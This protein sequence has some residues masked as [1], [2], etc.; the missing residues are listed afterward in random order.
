MFKRWLRLL[1][2][3]LFFALCLNQLSGYGKGSSSNVP[4][5]KYKIGVIVYD[6]SDVMQQEIN[7][8][9]T[10]HLAPAFN[11]EFIISDAIKDSNGEISFIENCAAKGVKGIIAFYNVTD[12][13]KILNLCKQH[14][15]YYVLGAMNPDE[16]MLKAAEGNPYFL[17][18]VGPGNSDY[19]A[20]Y[21]MTKKFLEDG[22][23]SIVL[24]TG[25]KDWSVKM[26]I[27][28][29]NGVKDAIKDFEAK[30]P[31]VKIKVYEF[32]GFPND[33]W[34]ATQAKMIA[35]NPDAIVAT[36]S[37]E[38]LWVQP[39]KDAGKAG[40]IKLGTLSSINPVAA[41]AMKEGV[42]HFLAGIY[43]QMTGLNFALLYN[44]MTG[45]AKDF[46]KDGKPVVITTD[47]AIIQSAQE[48]DKWMKIVYGKVP[49]YSADDLKKVCKVFNPKATYNDFVKL[50]K[51]C[52]YNDIIKRRGIKR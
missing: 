49:P 41:Q 3:V 1:W 50:C 27:D 45:Y 13:K 25:G 46:K 26:F 39:L 6:N 51:E 47:V 36:F 4:K 44:A 9:F 10:Q 31:G 29:Y 42:L 19:S 21:K 22:A 17:G 15:I 7:K 12:F 20:M 34:F 24:P 38:F 18:G 48:M 43:P 33:A 52:N 8:Y 16:K 30:H 32:G 5:Q 14:K 35:L 23:R 37:G 2:L 11:V 28:R 40:K